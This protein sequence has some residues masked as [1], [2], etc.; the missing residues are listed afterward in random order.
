MDNGLEKEQSPSRQSMGENLRSVL[1]VDLCRQ[2]IRLLYL[3]QDL[4]NVS[5]SFLPQLYLPERSETRKISC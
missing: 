2:W 1:D 4:A 5:W 3:L